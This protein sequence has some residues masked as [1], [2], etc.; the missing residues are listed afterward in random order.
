MLTMELAMRTHMLQFFLEL[1]FLT[2]QQAAVNLDLLLALSTLPFC[3]E[4]C[5]H[6]RARRGKSYSICASSTCKR[7]SRVCARW[8]KI[9]SMTRVRHENAMRIVINGK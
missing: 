2:T 1:V 9:I 3:R 7:P 8:P 6:W 5:P 4:R